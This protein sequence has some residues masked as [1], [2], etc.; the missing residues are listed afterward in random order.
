MC[1]S[2]RIALA[3]ALIPCFAAFAVAEEETTEPVYLSLSDDTA[4]YESL[5][6]L[7]SPSDGVTE[8]APLVIAE[9]PATNDEANSEDR[10]Q[11]ETED[12]ADSSVLINVDAELPMLQPEAPTLELTEPVSVLTPPFSGD[13]D[14]LM[15]EG[16][17]LVDDGNDCDGFCMDCDSCPSDPCL[18]GRCG[19]CP[20]CCGVAAHRTY[21]YGELL[22]LRARNAEVAYAVPADGPIGGGQPAP[23][24]IGRLGIVEPD[25]DLGF[26]IGVN[27]ALDTVSSL[28]LRFMNFESSS[29]DSIVAAPTDI[30]RSLV[31]HPSTLTAA[32]DALAGSGELD[33]DFQT[34]DLS[35][36]HV[37]KC[38]DIHSINYVLGARYGRLEQRFAA[39]FEKNGT[40]F[41]RSDVDFEGGGLRLG[42]DA[43]RYSCRNQLHVYANGY[44]NILAGRFRNHYFQGDSFDPEVV[45]VVWESGRF[46]PILDLECGVGW[47]SC[48]GCLRLSAGYLVSSW[49]NAVATRDV[50]DS[51]QRNDYRNLS[52][53]IT[54]D[55]LQARFEYRF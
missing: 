13:Q 50:I 11:P 21:M 30:L 32:D 25:Y 33:I 47:T 54:F 38:S 17:L 42:F 22:Y 27:V 18:S 37:A 4:V 43:A 51:V 5:S 31:T 39:Q 35:Y 49:F 55:G 44:A 29:F 12:Q 41:V 53:T 7:E 48:D 16:S 28:D 10:K 15:P 2:L 40:E 8:E 19:S 9:A 1:L 26:R 14:Q 34:L 24:Q 52:E 20:T 46:V 6:D 45:N 23:V 3:V 36:R